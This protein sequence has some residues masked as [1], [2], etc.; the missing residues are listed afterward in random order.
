MKLRFLMSCHRKNSARDKAI[1][2]K[3]I[4][5]ERNTPQTECGPS[6][7]QER[8][9]SAFFH[10]TFFLKNGGIIDITLY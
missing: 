4:Y 9:V 3:W 6:R 7:R 2:K 8:P 10:C 1:G 5:L